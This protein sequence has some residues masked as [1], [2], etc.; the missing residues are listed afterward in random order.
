M[1]DEGSNYL[2]FGL[3]FFLIVL[4]IV[5]CSTLLFL[6]V[7]SKNQ[8]KRVTGDNEVTISDKNKVD[9][10]EDF[11]YFTDEEV[12]S[13]ELNISYKRPIINLKSDAAKN[14][15]EEIKNYANTI[16]KTLEKGSSDACQYNDTANILKTNFLE[17]ATYTFQE[18]VTLL[19]RESEY[20]CAEGF[21]ST[22]KVKSYTFD[23]L[24]GERL[25]FQALLTKYGTT[26]TNVI[27]VVREHLNE[28]QTIVEGTPTILIEETIGALK[29]QE[30]Y[31]LYID[32]FGDLILN[33]VV[34]T[35]SVDYNDTIVI[36]RK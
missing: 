27:E 29:E 17:Y 18:F 33:Y 22:S 12:L 7:R 13:E 23:V 30:T 16:K 31:V 6:N 26:L 1:Q 15:N 5:G 3:F 32:E 4:I 19:I 21:S 8:E 2:G 10:K 35:N 24:S 20:T 36:N 11:I 34:K 28:E 25:S 9:K 14:I